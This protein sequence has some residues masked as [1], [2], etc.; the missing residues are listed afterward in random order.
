[1]DDDRKR[2]HEETK[3]ISAAEVRSSLTSAMAR[4]KSFAPLMPTVMADSGLGEFSFVSP[5]GRPSGCV[6]PGGSSRY[7][8]SEGPAIQSAG[9]EG[10]WLGAMGGGGVGVG[11]CIGASGGVGAGGSMATAGGENGLSAGDIRPSQVCARAR[12]SMCPCACMYVHVCVH[13]CMCAC[14]HVRMRACVGYGLSS[15]D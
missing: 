6:G 13:A 9:A 2:K 7:A 1:M 4:R 5:R 12:V 8:H 15:G 3:R 11:S 14:V 10:R